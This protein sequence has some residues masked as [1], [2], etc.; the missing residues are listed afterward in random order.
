MIIDVRLSEQAQGTEV[1][2]KKNDIEETRRKEGLGL[3]LGGPEGGQVGES[4]VSSAYRRWEE[5]ERGLV[6]VL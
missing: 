3:G 1:G 5:E 4:P 6:M 2:S